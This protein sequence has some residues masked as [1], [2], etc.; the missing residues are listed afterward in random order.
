MDR[1]SLM[2]GLLAP[3]L[4]PLASAQLLWQKDEHFEMVSP[5]MPPPT[6]GKVEV[7][8]VFSYG[9]PYCFGVLPLV[10]R[11]RES[12]PDYAVMNYVH[13][14]FNSAEAWPMFQR[15]YVTA[16]ALGIAEG[17]HHA[18]FSA[19]WQTGE[20]R[21]LN[22]DTGRPAQPLPNIAHVAAF[23]ARRTAIKEPEFLERSR[24]PDIDDAVRRS[25]MLV[26]AYGVPGTPCFIVNGKY[27]MAKG[28]RSS[29]DMVRAINHFVRLEKNSI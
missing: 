18:L 25:D 27:R 14:S 5:A 16:R 9:C 6:P 4:S 15:A 26:K 11:I 1:R 22:P 17:L 10:E 7:T 13:A 23:Y 2:L 19:I 28:I 24:Q 8:E 12:L 29:D 21:L 20:V 3:A